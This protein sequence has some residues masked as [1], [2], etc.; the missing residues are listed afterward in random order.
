M[1][2]KIIDPIRLKR[3]AQNHRR[4]LV[5]LLLIILFL[6]YSF[7]Q[8]YLIKNGYLELLPMNEGALLSD[9]I[10]SGNM[11]PVIFNTI[12]SIVDIA[13]IVVLIVGAVSCFLLLSNV[14]NSIIV[15]VILSLLLFIPFINII[16]LFGVTQM[17]TK[18]LKENKIKVG[19]LGASMSQ[20]K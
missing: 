5:C 14:Y 17:A 6:I 19:F 1:S 15:A 16:I 7:I 13:N 3:I 11:Q 4:L 12:N 20:F 2:K 9:T 10:L 8:M 18:Q